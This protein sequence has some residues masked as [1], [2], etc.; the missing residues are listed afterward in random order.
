L[1]DLC[2]I[3]P[4]PRAQA[5]VADAGLDEPLPYISD[6]EIAGFGFSDVNEKEKVHLTVPVLLY[7]IW[8]SDIA[9]P[10]NTHKDAKGEFS[11]IV[12]SFNTRNV[13]DNVRLC[14]VKHLTLVGIFHEE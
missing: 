1:S 4:K 14:K 5:S 12:E 11:E 7:I 8:L 3:N 10:N 6:D 13:L 9:C 2:F